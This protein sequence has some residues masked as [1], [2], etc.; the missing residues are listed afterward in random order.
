MLAWIN[1]KRNKKGFTLVELVVVIAILGILVALAVPRLTGA[2]RDAARNAHNSNV[3]M[4][5]SAV[6]LYQAQFGDNLTG[7]NMKGLYDAGL[8]EEETIAVPDGITGGP[9][10]TADNGVV[11]PEA[12]KD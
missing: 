8:L 11:S 1:K 3:R 9:N 7:L 10:Y 6:A 2:R 12:I 5:E 4:I